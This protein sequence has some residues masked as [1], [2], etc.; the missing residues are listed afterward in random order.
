MIVYIQ[1]RNLSMWGKNTMILLKDVN[2]SNWISCIE[3]D[4]TN[5]QRQYMNPNVFSLAEAFVHSGTRKDAE[6]YYRCIPFAIYN[7]DDII[8]FA[9]LTYETETDYDNKP[10]YEIY[11]I[12]IDK[13]HQGNGYGKTALG[14]LLE[15]INTLPCGSADNIYV[16]WHPD[17]IASKKL[18][19]AYGFSV[20]GTDEDG[21]V[22]AKMNLF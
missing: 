4:V 8:G 22:I 10:A 7:N 20:V 21:A 12:M 2:H 17:N 19:E 15:Y 1:L 5:E 3:L 11:R 9:M 14:L 18:F 13:K 16:E 6:E